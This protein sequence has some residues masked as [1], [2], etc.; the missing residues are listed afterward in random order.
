MLKI[1]LFHLIF[2]FGNYHSSEP[3]ARL[4]TNSHLSTGLP[5]CPGT[6]PEK[7]SGMGV[8]PMSV[9]LSM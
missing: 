7:T 6:S 3:A 5:E 2:L 9:L 1:L 4:L 8:S